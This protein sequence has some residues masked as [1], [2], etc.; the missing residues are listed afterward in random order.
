MATG[1]RA[2]PAA[3]LLRR[4]LLGLAALTIVGIAVELY[5]ESHWTDPVQL[6]AWAALALGV[7]A[8]ALL[9]GRPS[10]R[11]V[12]IAQVLAAIVVVS[13]VIG[14]WQHVCA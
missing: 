4:G 5:V 9:L 11:R 14:V 8:L 3:P 2:D 1:M 10:A 6:I 13:S 12:R 7:A